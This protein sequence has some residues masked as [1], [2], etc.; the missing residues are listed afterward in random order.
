M[1]PLYAMVDGGSHG[2]R[3][4]P[5]YQENTDYYVNNYLHM[6]LG[7]LDKNSKRFGFKAR[8]GI[9]V[10]ANTEYVTNN[11]GFRCK[12]WDGAAEILAVG[13][14]NTYGLGVP[15]DAS[16]PKIL[17]KMT[18]KNVHNLSHPGVSIQELVFQ[19]FSYFKEFGNPKTIVCLFPDPFRMIVPTKKGLVGVT[20][21]IEKNKFIESIHLERYT[22]EKISDRPQYLKI[23]YDYYD[24]LPME[25]AL[26][27]SMRAIHMLEQ[28]CAASEIK[29]IW[30]SWN[31]PILDIFDQIEN[32]PFTNFIN[33]K[34]FIV[35]TGIEKQC[36]TSY[37][38]IDNK[39]FGSGQDIESG[40]E[41][42]HCGVHKHIHIAEEFYKELIK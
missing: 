27:F 5:D 4:H 9:V 40:P 42:A 31:F 10:D 12:D 33:S 13:C 28:Y 29:L 32:L 20:K 17:E 1:N 30:S 11:F 21:D 38:N 16:W 34:E 19:M 25:F 18:N 23:P 3:H 41:H 8:A 24:I 22:N 35:D 15:S 7:Y 6:P 36:H 14:S 26:F 37:E 2:G 39:Y